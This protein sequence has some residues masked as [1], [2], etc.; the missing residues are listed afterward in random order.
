M[1]LSLRGRSLQGARFD[2]RI[3]LSR[4]H[5]LW[6]LEGLSRIRES[7]E[8]LVVDQERRLKPTSL[9]F[10]DARSSSVDIES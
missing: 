10:L 2:S 4:W 7:E 3:L 9:D 5:L 8:V 1:V 6:V